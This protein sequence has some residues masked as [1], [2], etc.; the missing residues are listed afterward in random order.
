MRLIDAAEPALRALINEYGFD[1]VVQ[2][3]SATQTTDA[4]A[5]KKALDYNRKLSQKEHLELA[6]RPGAPTKA[7]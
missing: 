1:A 2:I 4:S 5:L 6:T 3:V 7:A